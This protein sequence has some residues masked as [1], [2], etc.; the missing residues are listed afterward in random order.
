MSVAMRSAGKVPI[1]N[2]IRGSG[3]KRPNEHHVTSPR[4][5]INHQA[6]AAISR[7]VTIEP[8]PS[9]QLQPLGRLRAANPPETKLINGSGLEIYR[10]HLPPNIPVKAFWSLI[11]YDT[12]T[13]FGFADRPEG[14]TVDQRIGHGEIP[15]RRLSGRVFSDRSPPR[16]GKATGYRRC[17]V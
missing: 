6:K 11:P 9:R 3:G 1:I 2:G 14:H 17:H 10:L 16:A 13:P 5:T 8:T 7:A 12:Q 15:H 4:L